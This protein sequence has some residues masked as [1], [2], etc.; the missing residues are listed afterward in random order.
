MQEGM[1][2]SFCLCRLPLTVREKMRKLGCCSCQKPIEM[3][4]P[5]T[6]K[7]DFKAPR[8]YRKAY[9]NERAVSALCENCFKLGLELKFAIER[10][11]NR[12]NPKC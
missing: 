10:G 7:T 8:E 9:P 3:S 4:L 6:L 12:E 5:T 11:G 1:G 2:M